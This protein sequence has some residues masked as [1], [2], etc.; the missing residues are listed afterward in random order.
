MCFLC[1]QN[2][3]NNLKHNEHEIIQ[4]LIPDEKEIENY[5]KFIT[6]KNISIINKLNKWMENISSL[7]REIIENLN[8]EIMINK[9]IFNNFKLNYLDNINYSNYKNAL[10]NSKTINLKLKNFINSK[11]LKEETDILTSYFYSKNESFK[12]KSF[13]KNKHSF[14]LIDEDENNINTFLLRTSYFTNYPVSPGQ[15]FYF[16]KSLK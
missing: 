16:K 9:L 8:C 5:E 2:D 3:E 12:N 4:Y 14:S 15:K 11:T 13:N 10:L 1:Q 7:V 6:N